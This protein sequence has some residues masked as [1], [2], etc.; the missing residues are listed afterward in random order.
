MED[1]ARELV[2]FFK[3][4][5][6]PEFCLDRAFGQVAAL[7]QDFPGQLARRPLPFEWR[8][9]LEVLVR[10][11]LLLPSRKKFWRYVLAG[12]RRFPSRLF[13]FF[14]YLAFAEHHF[15]FRDHVFRQV[16]ADLDLWQRREDAP[17]EVVPLRG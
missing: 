9:I 8:L 13:Y 15:E 3:T 11:G 7:G 1:I 16:A 10:Q 5:Y 14:S 2:G 6:S 4:A 17:R 12:L